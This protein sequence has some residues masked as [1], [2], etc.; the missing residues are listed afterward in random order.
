M[1]I[2][3]ANVEWGFHLAEFLALVSSI[4]LSTCSRE[5][6]LV[7]G[8]QGSGVSAFVEVDGE[9]PGWGFGC[10]GQGVGGETYD[11]EISKS[12]RDAA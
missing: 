2:S 10:F 7:S 6:P 4:I 12:E 5:R 11:E 8:L 9:W 1:F 3:P